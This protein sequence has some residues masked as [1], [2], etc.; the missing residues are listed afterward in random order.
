MSND[1]SQGLRQASVRVVT[2]TTNDYN[3]DFSALFT[4]AGIADGPDFNG[5]LLAWVNLKLTAA[6][7]DLG[8][9]LNALATANGAYNWSSL[10]TFDA[11]TTPS[12]NNP[13]SLDFHI[14]TNSQYLGFV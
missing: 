8:S 3:G 14:N 10:G 13:G 4:G 9:A 5:R 1:V 11:S 6:Y 7:T 2:G 12:G